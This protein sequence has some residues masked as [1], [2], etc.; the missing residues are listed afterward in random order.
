MKV[1]LD[2]ER[3]EHARSEQAVVAGECP[4]GLVQQADG[5]VVRLDGRPLAEAAD[6]STR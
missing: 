1:Q 2:G 4:K 5:C 6:R 3:G